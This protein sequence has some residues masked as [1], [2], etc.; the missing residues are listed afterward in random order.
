MAKSEDLYSS[1]QQ[2][3]SMSFAF[4]LKRFVKAPQAM[5]EQKLLVQP[6]FR[7]VKVN[8][9]I[10]FARMKVLFRT[11]TCSNKLV[12]TQCP[13]LHI[14]IPWCFQCSHIHS[15]SYLFLQIFCLA[16]APSHTCFQ[17]RWVPHSN[18]HFHTLKQLLP[19]SYG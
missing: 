12:L 15:F 2:K 9:K 7:E 10:Y 13:L 14:Q 3:F 16:R 18:L 17:W 8:R 1:L 19:L 5:K 11:A 4:S 6:I